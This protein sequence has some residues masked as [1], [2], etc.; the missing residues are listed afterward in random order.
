[1]LLVYGIKNLNFMDMKKTMIDDILFC[2]QQQLLDEYSKEEYYT[3][4]SCCSSLQKYCKNITNI[5]NERLNAI[6]INL[7]KYNRK[8]STWN[9]AKSSLDEFETIVGGIARRNLLV[10]ID[11]HYQML[12]RIKNELLFSLDIQT[13]H[14]PEL[15]GFRDRIFLSNLK[16]IETVQIRKRLTKTFN[17][18][19]KGITYFDNEAIYS[20]NEPAYHRRGSCVAKGNQNDECSGAS[21][22]VETSQHIEQCYIER[23][24]YDKMWTEVLGSQQDERHLLWLSK[25]QN[26][27]KTC[28]PN[29][30]IEIELPEFPQHYRSLNAMNNSHQQ[31]LVPTQLIIRFYD[32]GN[33]TSTE[34]YTKDYDNVLKEYMYP[35][36]CVKTTGQHVFV[37]STNFEDGTTI[38]IAVGGKNNGCTLRKPRSKKAIRNDILTF[39]SAFMI[40]E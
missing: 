39:I 13:T 26:A 4:C 6:R 18:F 29:K 32:D 31:M 8:L 21:T 7:F 12:L 25:T 14:K 10:F 27:Y 22:D 16:D 33:L 34:I 5:M 30:N 28:F 37:K 9:N 36:D 2:I 1:M 20:S 24:I 15:I 23:L 11:E 3:F 17:D 35:V 38:W 19:I 40:Y